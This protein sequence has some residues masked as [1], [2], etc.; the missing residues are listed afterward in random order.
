MT[1]AVTRPRDRAN[2]RLDDRALPIPCLPRRV[3]LANAFGLQEGVLRMAP[4]SSTAHPA[5]TLATEG[6][7]RE[8][9]YGERNKLGAI[10]SGACASLRNRHRLVTGTCDGVDRPV[11]RD[12]GFAKSP[13]R[14]LAGGT[15]ASIRT[16]G[17]ASA[18][19]VRTVAPP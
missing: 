17:I 7:L 9:G 12:V 1:Q 8:E 2:H 19:V 10:R 14:A 5:H 3:H 13:D 16:P 6:A 4:D 18:T 11:N 15:G